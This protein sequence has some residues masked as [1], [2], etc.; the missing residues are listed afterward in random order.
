MFSV[1]KKFYAIF[2]TVERRS[3]CFLFIPMV[4]AAIVN[5]MGIAFVAPFIAIVADPNSI[6]THSKVAWLY[7]H[8]HFTSTHSFLLFLGVLVFIVLIIGNGIGALTRWLMLKFTNMRSFTLSKRLLENYLQQPYVY[9]LNKNSAV[10]SKNILSEV[11][12][13]VSHV[14]RNLLEMSSKCVAML[15]II[16]FLFLINPILA[17]GIT[18]TLGG[19]YV[20][21]YAFVRRRLGEV[22]RIYSEAKDQRYRIASKTFGGIKEIKL[23]GCENVF[24]D[25][26]AKPALRFANQQAT[27]QIIA[28]MPRYALEVIA[29][30]GIVLIVLYLL[31]TKQPVADIMPLLAIYA[32]SGYR[33]MPGFQTIFGAIASIRADAQAL[34][35]LHHDLTTKQHS[36]D[37]S[38]SI[39]PYERLSF[40][41]KLTLNDIQFIYPESKN[42]IFNKINFTINAGESVGIVG[43]TG[44]GKTTVVDIILALLQPSS[45]KILVDNIEIT[46]ENARHWQENLGYVPQHIYL[47]D[48]TIAHNIAFGIKPDEIDINRIEQAAKMAAIHEFIM[49][50]LPNGYATQVGERGIR[51][52]GGQRQRLGIARA[53][54]RDPQLLVLDEATSALDSITEEHI[55]QAVYNLSRKKTVIIIAHRLSTLI[56]CDKI[57]VFSK[58]VVQDVGTYQELILRNDNF[59]RLAK[60]TQ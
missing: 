21:I 54:Y 26:Y 11:D 57:Y 25:A 10:L 7:N 27:G 45:G 22:S 15:L 48:D 5:V 2:T 28:E 50:E 3:V 46:G 43:E 13:V 49:N 8:L 31:A 35:I 33:L 24:L 59:Q 17:A 18:L 34:D 53:L 32:F 30:G 12:V 52:S 29:F 19:A 39:K 55:M 60:V 20:I 40:T 36:A 6:N 23:H 44:A 14:L 41:E 4:L 51:L 38:H 56:A 9:F 16:S 47:S 58:G 42:T 37:V 1:V